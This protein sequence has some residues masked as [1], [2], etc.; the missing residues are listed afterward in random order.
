MSRKRSGIEEPED[1]PAAKR[2]RPGAAVRPSHPISLSHRLRIISNRCWICVQA[3]EAIVTKPKKRVSF[4]PSPPKTT[5]FKKDVHE[6][7][8]SPFSFGLLDTISNE[9]D[10][11]E[12]DD[13]DDG[14]HQDDGEDDGGTNGEQAQGKRHKPARRQRDAMV[15]GDDDDDAAAAD[16]A[17]DDMAA[18]SYLPSAKSNR[19]ERAYSDD[20][21]DERDG[22][23]GPEITPFNLKE[24]L[25][26]GHFDKKTGSYIEQ[27]K[28]EGPLAPNNARNRENKREHEG[29][30]WS[31]VLACV[32]WIR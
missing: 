9:D 29:A 22:R 2:S 7:H 12:D 25:S 27:V 8:V 21:D 14:E 13:D 30:R 17:D 3:E 20:Y 28:P 19:F 32:G 5:F 6:R 23:S 24:E 4:D 18:L 11:E 1:A 15:G 26:V 31:N 16:D 10:E